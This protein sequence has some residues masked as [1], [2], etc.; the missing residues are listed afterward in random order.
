MRGEEHLSTNPGND[1]Q[2]LSKEKSTCDVATDVEEGEKSSDPGNKEP[3]LEG[4]SFVEVES[5][6]EEPSGDEHQ[7]DGS[8][9]SDGGLHG[10]FSVLKM[11]SDS[12]ETNP[13]TSCLGEGIET[14]RGE[15]AEEHFPEMAD[16]VGESAFISEFKLRSSS[17]LESPSESDQGG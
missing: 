11:V 1:A 7:N 17:G 9:E 5:P 4:S 13:S 12:Q 6:S 3:D 16:S 15:E 10:V 14:S 2:E 8:P